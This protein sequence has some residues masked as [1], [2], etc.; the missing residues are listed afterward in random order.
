MCKLSWS[1]SYL[2][3]LLRCRT[4]PWLHTITPYRLLLR[5]GSRLSY[6]EASTAQYQDQGDETMISG[7]LLMQALIVAYV[8]TSHLITQE[9]L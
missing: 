2:S 3:L 5:K 9:E 8:T 1:A 7:M 6:L 4:L